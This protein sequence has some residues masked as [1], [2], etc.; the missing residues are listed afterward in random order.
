MRGFQMSAYNRAKYNAGKELLASLKDG[1]C[2]DCG[3]K[4]PPHV[5]DF[6]HRDYTT[7]YRNV[8]NMKHYPVERLR[9]EINKCDLVC[10]NCHRIRTWNRKNANL[11]S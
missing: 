10:A 11:H 3:N 9:A 5:M 6:D 2:A 8:G 4:F 1:P 7:K